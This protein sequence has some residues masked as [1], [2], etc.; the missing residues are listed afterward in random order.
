M[1]AAPPPTLMRYSL[2]GQSCRA[3]SMR[4][5]HYSPVEAVLHA[6]AVHRAAAYQPQDVAGLVE[7]LEA[8]AAFLL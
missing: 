2:R 7:R 5:P 4:V 6:K 8:V 1:P 3:R